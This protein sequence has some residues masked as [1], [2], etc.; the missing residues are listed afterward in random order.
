MCFLT[1][2]EVTS[3][4]TQERNLYSL[5]SMHIVGN[6]YRHYLTNFELIDQFTQHKGK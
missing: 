5:V 1:V 6:E 4:N 3:Y 2:T